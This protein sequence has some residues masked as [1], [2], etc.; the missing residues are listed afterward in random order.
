M[1]GCLGSTKSKPI[2]TIMQNDYEITSKSKFSN[3]KVQFWYLRHPALNNKLFEMNKFFKFSYLRL[4]SISG[5]GP[6][7]EPG[8]EEW[9]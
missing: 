8:H 2:K 5:P 9:N 3:Q 7:G 6:S 4:G 1:D